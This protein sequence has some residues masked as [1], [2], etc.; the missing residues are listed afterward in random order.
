M[1]ERARVVV[2]PL[3]TFVAR[4]GG[5]ALGDEPTPLRHTLTIAD[6]A[7]GAPMVLAEGRG[8]AASHRMGLIC[9]AAGR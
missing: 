2:I 9:P 5:H 4:A 7:V 6:F 8:S 3:G 1:R